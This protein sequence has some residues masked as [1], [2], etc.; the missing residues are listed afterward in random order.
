MKFT[1]ILDENISNYDQS[2]KY[3]NLDGV[4]NRIIKRSLDLFFGIVLLGLLL[5]VMLIISMLIIIDSGFPIFFCAKRGGY[6]NSV[7]YIVKF[8]TMVRNAEMIGGG[9]TGLNDPRV[10]KIGK[11]LRKTKLDEISQLINV[12]KGEMSFIGPRPELIK[13]TSQYIGENKLILCVKPGITD[14]SSIEFI[15]LDEIVG[16][17]NPDD[18]YEKSI[19]LHKNQLRLKYVKTISLITD[20]QI[21]FLTLIKLTKK[22]LPL[23]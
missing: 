22:L 20:V 17:E 23:H 7:F 5:P 15:N 1:K 9:T 10:T 16:D 21:L 4:Y 3:K 12:I 11:F 13:Y 2:S 6:K 18:V 8:R 19:L 14:F